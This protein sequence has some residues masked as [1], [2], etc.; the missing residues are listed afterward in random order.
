MPYKTKEERRIYERKLYRKNRAARLVGVR[1]AKLKT[2][3]GITVADYDAMFKA[4]NGVCAVC[5]R[6][7][8]TRRFAVDHNHSTHKVRGLLCSYCNR[9]RVASNTGAN[10]DAVVNYLRKYDNAAV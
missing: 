7:P 9:F 1:A 4:Q 8:K 3:F 6:P 10:I 5:G 2:K